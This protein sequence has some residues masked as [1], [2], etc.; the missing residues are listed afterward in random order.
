ME[1]S[2]SQ[3]I[4]II[5]KCQNLVL[6]K[7]ILEMLAKIKSVKD[8]AG[9]QIG[10]IGITRRV[11]YV[12]EG[13]IGSFTSALYETASWMERIG[14]NIMGL[15]TGKISLKSFGGPLMIG[16]IAGDLMSDSL[17]KFF[18]LMAIISINL[19]IINI[20][21]FPGLDGGHALIA[22]IE[23]AMGKRIPA[24][25][26]IL[27]Q[28]FGITLLMILFFVIIKNDVSTILSL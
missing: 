5:N 3:K 24:K 7:C 23:G 22:I 14:I 11:N 18:S 19:G 21:P 26:L 2:K 4:K 1:K 17:D 8:V 20:L 16:K 13:T 27:I 10:I 12:Y 15:F 28:W 9:I 25:T 6:F